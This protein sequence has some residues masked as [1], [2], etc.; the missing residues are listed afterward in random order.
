M[1]TRHLAAFKAARRRVLMLD[2]ILTEKEHPVTILP[3]SPVLDRIEKEACQLSPY[4]REQLATHLFYS[5]HPDLTAVD[6]AWLDLAEQRY[7]EL[8]SGKA[9]PLSED[10]FFSSVEKDFGWK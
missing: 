2:S 4:E 7:Q 10:A 1:W 8:L 9:I 3:M 6:E 5:V